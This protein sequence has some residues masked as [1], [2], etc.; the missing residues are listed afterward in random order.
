MR[1]ILGIILSLVLAP[2]AV[3]AA[4]GADLAIQSSGIFFSKEALIVGDNVRIYAQIQNVGDI[5]ISGYVS[6]YQGNI[7][8][9]D[10]QVVSVRAGGTLDEVYV[11]YIV[12]SG[13]FNIRA[14]IKGTDPQD[15]NPANDEAITM[16]FTPIHDDDRDGIEDENDNCPDTTNVD[17]L[18]SDGD[19]LGD[20]CDDD[21]DND[22][23][24]DD[25]EREIGT[26][27]IDI[28]SDDDGI[29]D[30][31]DKYPTDPENVSPSAPVTDSE[32]VAEEESETTEEPVEDKS[33]VE[34]LTS[35]DEQPEDDAERSQLVISPNAV[36]GY[37]KV[38]WNTYQFQAQ[39]PAD[40]SYKFEWDFGD[41][42]TSTRAEVEHS[43]QGA[44]EY[45]VTLRVTDPTGRISHDAATIN[46]T[47]FDLS[48]WTVQ[49]LVGLLLIVLILAIAVY[50]RLTMTDRPRRTTKATEEID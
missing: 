31:E 6:F 49:M 24:T 46:I 44:G 29:G 27:P 30:A 35:E 19:G 42:V 45:V 41:G 28:D 20:A 10:S 8:I 18:D 47:F 36:F 25:V 21:D 13:S 33:E 4:P 1:F 43:F 34:S 9:G 32:A 2:M 37:E 22:S 12:P 11:D 3:L 14:V 5:D 23:I 40:L 15:E 50:V 17:Q 16:L 26:N 38:N 7:P 48:N 39:G